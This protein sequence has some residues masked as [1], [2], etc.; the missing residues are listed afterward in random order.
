MFETIGRSF[1]LLKLCLHV[2]AVDKELILFPVF[3]SIG[4]I[5]VTLSFLGVSFGIGAFE[6]L[7]EGTS[8]VAD[9]ALLFAFYV[10]SYFIIIFFNSALVFAAHERLAG[11]DPNIRSGLNGAFHRVIT[12]LKWAVIAATVGLILRILAGQARERGG[13]IGIIGHIVV[14]LLGAAWTMVTFFVVPL[15]VIEHLSLGD[16]FK[17][18]LSM[19]RRTWGEQI[20]ANFGLGIAGLLV[21]LVAVLVCVAL[22]ALLSLLGTFGIVLGIVISIALLVGVALV[23][24]TLDGI[25]KAALYNYASDGQVPTLFPDDVVRNAFRQS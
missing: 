4:V 16:A 7:D 9:Y 8:S 11:G 25:F 21:G 23:F 5:L 10:A 18:S 20:V 15:I 1:R 12:I 3:S 24:A 19:L 2:L 17:K 14:Q 13:I 22:I 6:R